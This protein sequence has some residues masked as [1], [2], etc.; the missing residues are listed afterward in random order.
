MA[1]PS[2]KEKK[3]EYLREKVVCKLDGKTEKLRNLPSINNDELIQELEIH[4]IEL[5][6]QNEEL[7]RA[8]LE[9]EQ[10][11]SRYFSLFELAPVGYF[12][13]DKNGVILD[14]NLTSA[15]LLGTEGMNL[16]R[17]KF[18]HFI[19]PDS[20]DAFYLHCQKLSRTSMKQTC[21]LKLKKKDGGEFYAE[22]VITLDRDT[23][24]NREKF[25]ITLNDIDERKRAQQKLIEYQARLKSLALQLTT[26][27]EREKR[28]LAI[29][30]HDN[31]GQLLVFSKMKLEMLIKK[32]CSDYSEK[33][34]KEISDMLGRIIK[35]TESLT[36]DISS[37]VLNELGLGAAV[38]QWLHENIENKHDI[39][40]GFHC[41]GQTVSLDKDISALLFRNIKELIINVVKHAC[42][43]KVNV[44]IC[45][46]EELIKVTVEDDGIGFT[47][48]ESKTILTDGKFG[49]FSIRE[50]LEQ[51][52]GDFEINSAPGHGC[53]IK[54]C[55]PLNVVKNTG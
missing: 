8:Q 42:A 15:V 1:K 55:V 51:L 53:R 30:L 50:E 37:P 25:R 10:S 3:Q 32:A 49:H 23:Q 29:L 2:G 12:T 48:D 36:F 34:L 52:G 21:E 31:V 40:V 7:R 4:Q 22:L 47:S 11:R 13:L 20:Q 19:T 45:K 17:K 28:R 9:L 46:S 16:I 14:A 41:E 44:A 39:R 26:V 35:N 43:R 54:M 33:T 6:M 24:E 38:A 18:F 27:E 5:E